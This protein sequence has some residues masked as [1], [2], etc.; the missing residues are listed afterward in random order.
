MRA[1]RATLDE[2]MYA[3]TKLE[4]TKLFVREQV[5]LSHEPAAGM[6]TMTPLFV[7][8][9]I[10][11]A[12]LEYNII[13]TKIVSSVDYRVLAL[14]LRTRRFDYPESDIQPQSSYSL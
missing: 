8:T 1:V 11:I 6:L 7:Y 4:V 2:E 12:N 9:L 3:L 5:L 13:G 14:N 10:Y